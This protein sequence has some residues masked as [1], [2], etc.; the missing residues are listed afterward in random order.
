MFHVEGSLTEQPHCFEPP[1]LRQI[2]SNQ[3]TP[4]ECT[5]SDCQL[6]SGLIT[7]MAYQPA[8]QI[9][10]KVKQPL[11]RPENALIVRLVSAVLT[12]ISEINHFIGKNLSHRIQASQSSFYD[13]D[14][15][16]G[17]E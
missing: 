14:G 1:C 11:A 3:M 4:R 9:T 6:A 10:F 7:I 5:I 2:K 12:D 15:K 17:F 8:S 13:E 16:P